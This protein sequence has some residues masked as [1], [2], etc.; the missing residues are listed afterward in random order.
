MSAVK[1]FY[2]DCA[3]A[4]F[5]PLGNDSMRRLDDLNDQLDLYWIEYMTHPY[6]ASITRNIGRMVFRLNQVT[7]AQYGR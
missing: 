1:Q 3:D 7:P 5:I 4:G 2:S 6:Q